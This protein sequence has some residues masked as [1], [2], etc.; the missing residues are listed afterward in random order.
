[1]TKIG[2]NEPCP[3]GSGKKYKTCCLD[4]D[5]EKTPKHLDEKVIHYL[6]QVMEKRYFEMSDA[7]MSRA[8]DLVYDG[9]E[10]MA[11]D[12]R[13]AK[14]C[15]EGAIKLDPDLADAYNGLAEV[16]IAR[17]NFSAAERD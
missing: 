15:F 8:Q 17:G 7:E 11:H 1:M 14:K 10:A 5:Q 12:P 4:K 9:W 6:R 13:E 3:C 2:R 16:A